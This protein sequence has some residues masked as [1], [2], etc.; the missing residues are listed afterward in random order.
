MLKKILVIMLA[1]TMALCSF[2]LS[3]FAA[4]GN[5]VF[6]DANSG[7]DSYDGKTASTAKKSY[8]AVDGS[9][10][11][12]A[13]AGFGAEGGALVISGKTR[14]GASIT[15]PEIEGTLTITGAWDGVNYCVT[16]PADNPA[17]GMIKAAGAISITLGSDTVLTDVILFQEGVTQDGRQNSIIVPAGKTLTITDTVIL[18]TMPGNDAYWKV[19]VEEGGKAILSKQAQEL[20]TIENH[21]TIETYGSDPV[22]LKMTVG[23]TDYTLNGEQKT[24]DVAPVIINSRTMLPVRYVAEALGAEIAWDGATSTATLTTADTVIVIT[25]GAATATVNGESVTLDSPAVIV[26]DRSFMPVRFVAETLGATVA[27][28][29][30]TSTAT[31]TK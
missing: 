7:D 26:S 4:E 3:A 19:V 11:M 30:A 22:E 18:M 25:V 8:G 6:M 12:N 29:G 10:A 20:L 14:P 31:I 17:S 21:G 16:E 5:V 13:I 2:S 24:M 1:A 27:W 9:G 23:K 28:D 15:F